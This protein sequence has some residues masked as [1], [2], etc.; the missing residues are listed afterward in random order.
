MAAHILVETCAAVAAQ[1]GPSAVVEMLSD[2]GPADEQA[3]IVGSLWRVNSPHAATVLQAVANAHPD[4]QVAKAARKAAFKLQSRRVHLGGATRNPASA[5]V[6]QQARN[7]SFGLTGRT[8]RFLIR[9]RDAKYASSFDT[10]FAGDG[11]EVILT[12][13]QA[14]RANVFAE[15][16]VRTVRAECLDWTLVLGRRHLERIL[17]IYVAH[18]NAQRPHRGLDLRTPDGRSYPAGEPLDRRRVQGREVLGGLIHEY[19]HAA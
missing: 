11:I 12:L 10:V 4:K 19:G 9:D 3:A 15:R 16:W 5:W 14:P 7:L 2:L 18:Y 8:F 13:V 17:R 1:D 6:T